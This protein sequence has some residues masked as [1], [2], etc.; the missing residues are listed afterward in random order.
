[1]A[2]SS[3]TSVCKINFFRFN[4]LGLL[5]LCDNHLG[6]SVAVIQCKWL[7]LKG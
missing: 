7:C 4:H 2:E 3:G 5:V 1:M 6:Y